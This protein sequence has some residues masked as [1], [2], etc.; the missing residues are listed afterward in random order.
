[1]E[2]K[3]GDSGTL[4]KK[5]LKPLVDQASLAFETEQRMAVPPVWLQAKWNDQDWEPAAR[6]WLKEVFA[7]FD[8]KRYVDAGITD[9]YSK[10][11][12][13]KTARK[14]PGLDQWVTL[15]ESAVQKAM[16][17]PI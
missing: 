6:R 7:A 17:S 13:F 10:A 15:F 8:A 3:E 16:Q 4:A 12:W 14:N 1:D 9:G 11:A 2:G 5:W